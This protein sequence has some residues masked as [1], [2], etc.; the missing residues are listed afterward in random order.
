MRV[1]VLHFDSVG[2]L[3]RAFDRLLSCDAVAS[4]SVEPEQSR[5]LFLAPPRTARPLLERFYLEGGLVWCS[6][7][8]VE[9]SPRSFPG[10]RSV[11]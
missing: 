1:Y 6:G 9:Q 8:P 4:C 7:H 11:S 2:S 10:P 3:T 5:I